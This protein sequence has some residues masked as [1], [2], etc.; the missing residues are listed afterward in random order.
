MIRCRLFLGRRGRYP[1]RW[2]LTFRYFLNFL[3]FWRNIS[4]ILSA[5]C[6]ISRGNLSIMW[7]RII[8][9]L[10]LLL[11]GWRILLTVLIS[12]WW[13]WRRGLLTITIWCLLGRASL[14]RISLCPMMRIYLVCAGLSFSRRRSFMILFLGLLWSIISIGRVSFRRFWSFWKIVSLRPFMLRR[15]FVSIEKLSNLP[16]RNPTT[17]NRNRNR[18]RK[19]NLSRWKIWTLFKM[20]SLTINAS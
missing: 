11:R 12:L 5:C 2:L 16:Q 1:S 17:T 18:N 15:S 3:W 10:Y 6:T 20:S 19:M 9:M 14:F 13:Y 7:Y 8:V 4:I